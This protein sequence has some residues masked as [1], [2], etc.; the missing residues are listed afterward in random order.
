[1]AFSRATDRAQQSAKSFSLSYWQQSGSFG[2]LF[3]MYQTAPIQYQR[4]INSAL[5]GLFTKDID[6]KRKISPKQAFKT[7]M[8]YHVVLPQ[9]FQAM[10]TAF[11][12]LWDDE[13]TE[14]WLAGQKRAL[15]VGNLNS[16]FLL[17]Q[18]IESFGRK[19]SGEQ[20]FTSSVPFLKEAEK[21]ATAAADA[22][23]NF[24]DGESEEA[25]MDLIEFAGRVSSFYGIPY[26]PVSK[27]TEAVA[28]VDEK[29]Y[30]WL[31]LMGFSDYALM[32]D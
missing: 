9:I 18:A 29:E 17:G 6:G 7:V 2:K 23:I 15:F 5:L 31:S 25:T 20:T 10:G 27:L 12:G 4:N 24:T 22:Y 13:T 26:E 21:A 3:L 19:I 11:I 32:Q 8:I 1:M 14:E 16:V 30:P 28:T